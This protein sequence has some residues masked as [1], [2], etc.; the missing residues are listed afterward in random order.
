[1][2]DSESGKCDEEGLKVQHWI[3]NDQSKIYNAV[4]ETV[5]LTSSMICCEITLIS[6][7]IGILSIR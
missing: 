3:R 7:W 5:K 6:A 1:M 4:E 2:A